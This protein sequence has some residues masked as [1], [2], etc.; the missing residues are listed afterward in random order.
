MMKLNIVLLGILILINISC[1]SDKK[2]STKSSDQKET[3]AVRKTKTSNQNL[4]ISLFLDLSDRISPTKYPNQSM[5]YYERDLGYISS[6]SKAFNLHVRSKKIIQMNDRIQLFF[7]PAPANPEI[8]N[9]AKQLKV[10]LTK[11]NVTK[12]RLSKINSDYTNLTKQIY[13]LAISDN[14]YIGSDIWRFFKSS[15]KDYCIKDGYRNILVILTDG[16]VYHK[17]TK[18]MEGT[19]SSYLTPSVISKF[20]LNKSDWHQKIEKKGYSFITPTSGLENLEILVLGINPSKNNPYEED[21][22]KNYWSTWLKE[23]GVN[24]HLIRTSDLPSNL[25]EVIQNF[26][27]N[28]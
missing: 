2:D 1:Q 10:E 26:I 28:G 9:L 6:V 23:M 5:E 18:L 27:L 12:E 14:K 22:I 19:K 21:V 16:Y 20:G 8:N 25:D 11:N 17:D 7:D 4:N 24:N 3:T 15:A 13:E